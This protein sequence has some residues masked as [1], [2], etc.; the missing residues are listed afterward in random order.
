M[1][2]VSC[3]LWRLPKSGCM[4]ELMDLFEERAPVPARGRSLA[5]GTRSPT[6]TANPVEGQTVGPRALSPPSPL[7]LVTT[8]SQRASDFSHSAIH[9]A[10]SARA[11]LVVEGRLLS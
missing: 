7:S 2:S 3:F 9:I 4:R 1:E 8:V 6:A 10:I 11:R 5:A